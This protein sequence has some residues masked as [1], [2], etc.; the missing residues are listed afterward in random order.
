MIKLLA[1]AIIIIVAMFF[2]EFLGIYD[3]PY[4]SVPDFLGSRDAMFDASE[5]RMRQRFGD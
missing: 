4:F 2:I 5:E 3:I 1:F